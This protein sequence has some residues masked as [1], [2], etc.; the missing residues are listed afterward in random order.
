MYSVDEQVVYG[1]TGVC[2]VEAVGPPPFDPK[3][4]RLYYTLRPLRGTETICAPVDGPAA[5]R[6]VLT[7]AQALALIDRLPAIRADSTEGQ[8]ARRLAE[9]Y[10][11]YLD[12]HSC[13]DLARLVKTVYGKARAG[14]VDQEFRRRAEGLLHQEL[15]VALG[16]DPEA[17]PAFIAARLGEG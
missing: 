14:K 15:G 3:A 8:D 11:G 1:S 7:R 12:T 10:R 2:R 13:E 4:A 16:L 5:I 6:P 17:V 9:Q